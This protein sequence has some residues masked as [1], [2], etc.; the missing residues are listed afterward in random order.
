[1][2]DRD[3]A[4]NAHSAMSCRVTQRWLRARVDRHPRAGGTTRD[5]QTGD[6]GANQQQ[7]AEHRRKD[8]EKL[9]TAR[10]RDFI[11]ERKE[12]NTPTGVGVRM[13]GFQSARHCLHPRLGAFDGHPGFQ[14]TRD[15]QEPGVARKSV[16]KTRAAV[17]HTHIPRRPK[18]R[19]VWHEVF[20]HD[21]NHPPIAA[22][23]GDRPT[24]ELRI[25]AQGPPEAIT[26][27]DDRFA[28]R[29]LP[30]RD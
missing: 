6:V 26:E 22:F 7:Q 23:H 19:R 29:R 12:P 15:P 21:T 10:A 30:R 13:L 24:H 1:M 27:N 5:G 17:R 16:R 2:N 25:G 3:T 11:R 14:P 4:L 20:R 8:E 28:A 18:G 9:Q